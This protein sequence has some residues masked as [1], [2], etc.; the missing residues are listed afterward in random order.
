MSEVYLQ[1]RRVSGVGHAEEGGVA[2]VSG[3][4]VVRDRRQKFAGELPL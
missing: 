4:V 2:K 1:L 3:Y